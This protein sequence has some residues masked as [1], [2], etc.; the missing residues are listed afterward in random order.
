MH[1]NLEK[2]DGIEYSM[3]RDSASAT[4]Q[5]RKALAEASVRCE[6]DLGYRQSEESLTTRRDAL[7]NAGIL[8]ADK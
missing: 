2:V 3:S 4:R 6:G 1:Q 8:S 7:N 5:G